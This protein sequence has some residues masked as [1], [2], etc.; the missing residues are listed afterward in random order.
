MTDAHPPSPEPGPEPTPEEFIPETGTAQPAG[1]AHEAVEAA[2]QPVSPDGPHTDPNLGA[3]PVQ[4]YPEPALSY[5]AAPRPEPQ[6]FPPPSGPAPGYPGFA[7][8]APMP[9]PGSPEYR[10]MFGP[11]PGPAYPGMLPPAV[12]Y[13]PQE[14]RWKSWGLPALVLLAVAGMLIAILTAI[15]SAPETSSASQIT[16]TSASEALQSYLD[17]LADEDYDVIAR[18]ALCGLYDGVTDRRGELAVSKLAATAYRKQFSRT[19]VTSIDEMVFVSPS[20]AQVLFTMKTTPGSAVRGSGT[21]ER[22]AIAQLQ[23]AGDEILV[24]SYVLRGGTF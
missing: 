17:A 18:N 19:E 5:P 14:P 15:G 2:P 10:R 11:N 16:E 3:V 12:P 1:G 9:F 20:N 7:P 8:A 24:C 21:A 6:Y 13:Q 23:A 4:P 22:Q